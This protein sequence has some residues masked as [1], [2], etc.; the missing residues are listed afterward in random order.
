MDTIINVCRD[1][2]VVDIDVEFPTEKGKQL[3]NSDHP[4]TLLESMQAL[5]E[6]LEPA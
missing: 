4:R 1:G 6:A 5:G 3:L 2:R